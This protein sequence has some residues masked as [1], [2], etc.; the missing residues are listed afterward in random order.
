MFPDEIAVHCPLGSLEPQLL[1]TA[2]GCAVAIVV[3]C[4]L[5]IIAL[6]G[7]TDND[8]LNA[9]TAETAETAETASPENA[10]LTRASDLAVE[11][12]AAGTV[13][14]KTE[15]AGRTYVDET[16]FI[17]DSNTARYMMYADET[18]RLSPP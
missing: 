3:F 7:R 1:L 6:S 8:V 12:A 16:L 2:A 18:G 5:L 10:A 4:C 15:D 11:T 14:G 17:G 9:A 13:L